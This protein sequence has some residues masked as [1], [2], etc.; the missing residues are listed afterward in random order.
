MFNF[1]HADIGLIQDLKQLVEKNNV[2]D[3]N[4]EGIRKFHEQLLQ[5]KPDT[6]QLLQGNYLNLLIS[7]LDNVTGNNQKESATVIV[8]C[9]G[10]I[11]QGSK[12]RDAVALKTVLVVLMQQIYDLKSNQLIQG[13]SEE[14]K[15]AILKGLTNACRNIQSDLVEEVYVRNNI[16]LLSQ[17]LIICV[18]VLATE[19]FRKLRFQAIY[20]ILATMQIHD[21]SDWE[22]SV[23]RHHVAEL[24]FIILPKLLSSLVSVINGDRKQGT[25]VIRMA[26]KALGRVICLIFEDYEKREAEENIATEKFAKLAIKLNRSDRTES[27]VLGMGLRDSAAK[28]NYFNNTTR[29]REWLLAADK[30]VHGVLGLITHLRGVE[31]DAFRQEYARM[32]AELLIRCVPNMP[33]CSITILESLLALCQ[34]ESK[35]IRDFCEGGLTAYAS[36]RSII[37]GSAR[38]DELFYDSLKPIS[39]SIYRAEETDQVAQFA[40]LKGYIKF[41]PDHQLNVILSN[42]ETLNQLVLML[43]AGAELAQSDELVRREYV[44]YCFQYALKASDLERKQPESRWIVLRNFQG[45]SRSQT[46]FL[47]MLHNFKDRP[48]SLATILNYIVEDLFTTKLNAHGYLFILSELIFPDVDSPSLLNIFQNVFTEIL[49]SYHWDLE[50]EETL[51]VSDLKFNVLHICLALRAVDRFCR[52]FSKDMPSWQLYDVLRNVLPLTGCN[53]NCLNESAELALD[54]IAASVGLSSIHELISRNLDY[55]SQYIQRCLKRTD[56]FSAGVHMLQSVL[57]Y[58]PYETS[59]V[60]ESTVSPI[61]MNILDDHD[62]RTGAGRILCLRMLQIFIRAIRF[63]YRTTEKSNDDDGLKNSREKLA[64]KMD[65]L[66]KEVQNKLPIDEEA[67]IEELPADGDDA[68]EEEPMEPDDTN[69]TDERK[70]PSHIAMTIK[71]LTVNFKY[72]GSGVLEEKIIALQTLNEGIHLLGDHENQLLPMVHQIWFNFAERFADP[73]PVVVSCAFDL[74]VSLARLA[75]DFIRKRTL[76]DVLPRLNAF[77]RSNIGADFSALQ[78]FK[79]Q[80]KILVHIPELVKWLKLNERQLNQVL[81]VTKLYLVARSERRELQQLA[82]SCFDR[83]AAEYDAGAVFVKLTDE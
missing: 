6:M 71:I 67:T 23:L 2:Q 54:N 8:E 22:D 78:T 74:L 82:A 52:L 15:L 50:L 13:L 29:S 21:D 83:L 59:A 68:G 9:I 38:I 80:R 60:L 3:G 73:S 69:Q 41:L 51:H 25:A 57:R 42:Q 76:D 79:L 17:V 1:L 49:H 34:D 18:G 14:Y 37:F 19:R 44:S 46:A 36:R 62:Q 72:L 31:E 70:L 63:R 56:N 39:R 24:L 43:L 5:T 28:A 33:L 26:I 65:Q 16:N 64:E 30:K 66:K 20:C 55:I 48:E 47:D 32:N 75:K 81:S 58:V 7:L 4:I 11:L 35:N 61:V 77:M 45:S 12:L 10:T 40:L 27:N 53:L